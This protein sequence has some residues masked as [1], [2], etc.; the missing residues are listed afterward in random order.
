[1]DDAG[2]D[3]LELLRQLG[4]EDA[5]EVHT[6]LGTVAGLGPVRLRIL[7]R[8]VTSYHQD[9][10]WTVEVYDEL[11]IDIAHHDGE[12]LAFALTSAFQTIRDRI[13]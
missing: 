1:M 6:Y 8:G 11:D 12:R 3:P 13:G 2:I 7:D 9:N 5:K 10:R 4:L